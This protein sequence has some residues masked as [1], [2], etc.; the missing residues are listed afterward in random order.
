MP[1]RARKRKKV[2]GDGEQSSS[3]AEKSSPARP[4]AARK[5]AEGAGAATAAAAA[6]APEPQQAPPVVPEVLMPSVGLDVSPEEL[7]VVVGAIASAGVA[8]PAEITPSTHAEPAPE[9]KRP[10]APELPRQPLLSNRARPD[11]LP[12]GQHGD[13]LPP[14]PAPRRGAAAAVTSD[15][16][17]AVWRAPEEARLLVQSP[18]RLY[19][20]WRFAREP[21]VLL[22]EAL[23]AAADHFSPAVRL[24]DATTG[25]EGA[26]APAD[27]SDYWFDVLPGRLLRAEVGFHGEGLPFVRL[28]SSNTVETPPVGVS[29]VADA[30]PRFGAAEPEFE[31]VLEATGFAAEE[32]HGAEGRRAE[33]PRREANPG[34]ADFSPDRFAPTATREDPPRPRASSDTAARPAPSPRDGGHFSRARGEGS[35]GRAGEL[36]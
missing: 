11:S 5:T 6:V 14:L 29:P 7:S 20:Y 33:I 8:K 1:A 31:R 4:R 25:E 28:I 17:D 26:P 19:L 24:V 27:G 35:S 36:F 9:Q 2:P 18:R 30:A 12:Y 3:A 10:A 23:G 32:R 21:R 22:R 34:D 13:T 15:D 16:D